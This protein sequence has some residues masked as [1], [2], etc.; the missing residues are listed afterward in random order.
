MKRKS[1]LVIAA[2]AALIHLAC[3][4]SPAGSAIGEPDAGASASRTVR[5]SGALGPIDAIPDA[6]PVLPSPP[7]AAL[8]TTTP[9]APPLLAIPDAA[10]VM[11]TPDAATSAEMAA[12]ATPPRILRIRDLTVD[13]L[14]VGV[15]YAHKVD[16]RTG[17]ASNRGAALSDA[18]LAREL[19]TANAKFT[20]LIAD[21]LYAHDI[22]AGRV[23]IG[24]THAS[25]VSI[26]KP[27]P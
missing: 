22:H 1:C 13:H 24:E 17:V 7:D 16:A 19:G 26:E 9:D 6:S 18:D 27:D 2:G 20:E 12:E 21:V 10:P 3:S 11:A 23:D 15:V 5:P 8:P 14:T 4:P 25:I